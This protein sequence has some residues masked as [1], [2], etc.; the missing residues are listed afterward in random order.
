MRRLTQEFH[1][2]DAELRAKDV[3][4][5]EIKEERSAMLL[6]YVREFTEL[7]K[8]QASTTKML[9]ASAALLQKAGDTI[10]RQG[11]RL[12]RERADRDEVQDR[13]S[14][15]VNQVAKHV[16]RLRDAYRRASATMPAV[17]LNPFDHPVDFNELRLLDLVSFF[18]YIFEEL[19][20]VRAMVGAEL[21]KEG[22]RLPSPLPG[23]SFQGSV[24]GIHSCHWTPSLT[25]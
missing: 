13:L 12:E 1:A 9:E 25:S 17:G 7:Q 8:R 18:T 11:S 15:L 20:R 22:C 3:E 24:T 19:S 10:G 6:H 21:D 4:L 14:H 5:R 23:E 2:K 16:L